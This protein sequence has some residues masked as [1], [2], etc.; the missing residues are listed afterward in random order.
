MKGE[1]LAYLR[2]VNPARIIPH[3]EFVGSFRKLATRCHTGPTTALLRLIDNPGSWTP[4]ESESLAALD[5]VWVIPGFGYIVSG[6][7]VNPLLIPVRF[8]LRLGATILTSD[9]TSVSFRARPDLANVARGCDAL[10]DRAGFVA[11]FRCGQ[12]SAHDFDNALLKIVYEEGVTTCH[13]INSKVFQRVGSAVAPETLLTHYPSLLSEP[14]FDDL[15]RALR[16][17]DRREASAWRMLKAAPARLAIVC[18]LPYG[19]SNAYLMA[20]QIRV[21]IGHQSSIGVVLIADEAATRSDALALRESLAVSAGISCALV[22]A[23][24][25]DQALYS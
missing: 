4:G 18:V 3:R 22:V 6:W 12:I 25:P 20:E 23:R 14:F 21:H 10:L 7:A 24:R 16:D 1:S 5:C 13:S 11:A 8:S 2:C 15:A 19:R 17:T 9:E